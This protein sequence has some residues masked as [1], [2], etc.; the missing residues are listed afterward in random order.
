MEVPNVV[1]GIVIWIGEYEPIFTERDSR[2]SSRS[3]AGQQ[4][5]R[6]PFDFFQHPQSGRQ[7]QER[8]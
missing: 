6:L 1:A 8:S 7:S 3:D 2:L 4:R 5:Q